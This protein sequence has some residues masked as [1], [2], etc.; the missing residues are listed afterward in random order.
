MS[1]PRL[2]LEIM[3]KEVME[4]A[5]RPKESATAW[6]KVD[7]A[8]TILVCFMAAANGYFDNQL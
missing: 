6:E 5:P 8:L 1:C 2:M 3:G 4:E 7:L